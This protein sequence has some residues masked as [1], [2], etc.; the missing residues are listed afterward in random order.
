MKSYFFFAFIFSITT[1]YACDF[2]N[3]YVGLNPQYKK[4]LIGLRYYSTEYTGSHH[5]N[6]ELSELG[7]TNGTF[8]EIRNIYEL[9]G[10][11]FP[12]RKIQVMFSLP[13]V[14]NTERMSADVLTIQ[15]QGSTILSSHVDETEKVSGISDPVLI[16]HYQ[17][18]N[19]I[20]TDSSSFSHR[21]LAGGGIKFPTG[22]WKLGDDGEQEERIHQPGTGSFDYLFDAIYLS[23]F[24]K[25]GFNVN[26]NYMITTT[27]VEMFRFGN[28][29][30]MNAS[31]LYR[32]NLDNFS[33]YPSAGAYYEYAMQDKYMGDIFAS[34]GGKIIFAHAG[35]DIY[36]GNFSFDSAFQLPLSQ[37]LNGTQ[38]KIQERIIAGFTYAFR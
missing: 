33:F 11:F 7:I 10:Q 20:G 24:R 37:S 26:A 12:A 18:F 17:V 16:A 27:N 36:Y 13:Y 32:V 19:F 31:V 35:F 2:C 8:S 9:H 21:L 29:F 28:K 34:S 23:Q 6:E 14:V 1:S 4:N 22:K 3:C 38:P 25:I 30:N 15:G 5:S